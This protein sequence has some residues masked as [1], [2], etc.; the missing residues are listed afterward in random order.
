MPAERIDKIASFLRRP[1]VDL[2]F[3]IHP[4]QV[5]LPSFTPPS[6][7]KYWWNW[8][9]QPL[10]QSSSSNSWCTTKWQLLW[11]YYKRESLPNWIPFPHEG[12]FEDI[13][14]ELRNLIDQARSLTI[15]RDSIPDDSLAIPARHR[16]CGMSPKKAHEVLR[17][18][19]FISSL[20]ETSELKP[21]HVVD[22]GAG[23]AYLSRNLRDELG[24]HVLALDF[25]EVQTH[26]AARREESNK[27]STKQLKQTNGVQIDGQIPLATD[28]NLGT[29]DYETITIDADSL[30]SVTNRWMTN[31]KTLSSTTP[32]QGPTPILWV[33]LHACGSL[34]LDILRAFAG[35]LQQKDRSLTWIPVG[36][37]IVG[38]CYNMLRPEDR[39]LMRKDVTL[40]PNHLQLAAQTPDQWATSPAKFEETRLAMRKVAWRALLERVLAGS[41]VPQLSPNCSETD[42]PCSVSRPEVKRLGRLNDGAYTNWEQF[43]SRA[44]EKMGVSLLGEEMS[45]A[46]TKGSALESRLEVFHVLRCIL[47]SIVESFILLDRQHWLREELKVSFRVQWQGCRGDDCDLHRA[48]KGKQMYG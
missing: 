35:R 3:Q 38:C 40:T 26:G 4:N 27:R 24:L 42:G 16:T 31:K 1:D 17:M 37:V 34:T 30:V 6:E 43:V 46:G 14:V 39:V 32:N 11:L 9:G 48:L 20:I 10:D 28:L 44:E 47:G 13:P 15:P 2:Y 8:A 41:I 36:A 19:G 25:S 18:T 45:S 33:A 12:I 22:I 21:R 23:Q 5:A 7:W 29:L